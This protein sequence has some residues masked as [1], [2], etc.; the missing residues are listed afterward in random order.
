M[1]A[2]QDRRNQTMSQLT[3]PDHFDLL[4][5]FAFGIADRGVPLS[6]VV[7]APD[8]LTENPGPEIRSALTRLRSDLAGR[9]RRSDRLTLREDGRFVALLVDCNRQGALIFADRMTVAAGAF[10]LMSGLTVSCGIASY[11]EEITSPEML[12]A[13]AVR[14]LEMAHASGG[15][16]IEIAER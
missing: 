6:L 16:R 14:A 3:P 11:R 15:N 4:L 10:S 2:S 1:R 8:G 7:M 12:E 9:T 5:D 13:E